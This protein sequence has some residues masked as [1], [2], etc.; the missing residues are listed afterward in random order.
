LNRVPHELG[1]ACAWE[2]AAAGSHL[3]L[4]ARRLD[5]LNDL[6]SQITLKYPSVKVL[7]LS[8][9]VCDSAKIKSSVES[10]PNDFKNVHV[11][12]NNA[13]LIIGMDTVETVTESVVNTVLD[14]NVKGLLFMTQAI[15]PIMKKNNAGNIINISSIAGNHGQI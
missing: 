15:L 3:I 9:D 8:L 2:F 11:L 13:G 5:R 4:A 1:A 6:K 7:P 10:L 14:T 12:V